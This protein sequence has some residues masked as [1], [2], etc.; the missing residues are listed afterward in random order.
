MMGNTVATFVAGILVGL[1]LSLIG[2]WHIF[3]IF[4]VVAVVVWFFVL[5]RSPRGV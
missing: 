3:I 4:I 1:L 5:R 2:F